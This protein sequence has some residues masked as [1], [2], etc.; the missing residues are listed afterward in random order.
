MYKI[1]DLC[2]HFKGSNLLEKNIYEIL[3][4]NVKGTELDES[5]TY[6]GEAENLSLV[7]DLVVYK[8]I[9]QEGK[10][11]A[12]EASD[13][14]SELSLEKQAQFHQ[15]YKAQLLTDEEIA[16]VKSE[17]FKNEKVKT[18]EMKYGK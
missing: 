9:F 17:D 18:M 12:R 13:I 5:V 16:I 7:I 3:N 11:F 8:N 15:T 2:K 1:G 14:S 10:I 4:I 6:T